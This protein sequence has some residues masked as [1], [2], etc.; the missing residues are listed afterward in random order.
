LKNST[1]GRVKKNI[2]L[3]YFGNGVGSNCSKTFLILSVDFPLV[4]V[5]TISMKDKEIKEIT[6]KPTRRFIRRSTRPLIRSGR[7]SGWLALGQK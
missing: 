3:F 1:P 5:H 2:Q 4:L 7:G 6:A